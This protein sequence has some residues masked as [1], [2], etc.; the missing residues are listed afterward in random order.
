MSTSTF[1]CVPSVPVYCPGAACWKVR[2]TVIQTD[3]ARVL[4]I[5]AVCSRII[6]D[7]SESSAAREVRGSDA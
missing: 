4:R 1:S 5:C 3:G 2:P 7:L 6:E